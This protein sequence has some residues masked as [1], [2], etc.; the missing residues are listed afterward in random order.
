MLAFAFYLLKVIICSAV[1]FGYYWFFLRNKIFHSYNRFYLLAI[2]VLSLALPLMKISVWH[3][4]SESQPQVIRMLQVVNSSDEYLDEIVVYSHYNHISKEQ[5]FTGLY[6]AICTV[7]LFLLLQ[8][9]FRIWMLLKKNPATTIENIHFINT[10]AKG[11]PF[12]FLKF[13]FWNDAID[14]HTKTGRQVFKHEVAHVQEK[15]SYDKLFINIILILF[16]CNPFFWFIRKELNMIHEFIADK[17][18]VEDGDTADFAAMILQATYPQ[19]RFPI[20]NNFFYSPIKRR[21]IMLTKQNKTKV[22]YISRL[23]VLPL[24]IF[25]FAAFTIKAKTYA[26]GSNNRTITV[27]ID[28]GHG[29]TDAGATSPIDG[30]TYEKDLNLIIAQ[31]IRALNTNKDINILLTRESDIYQSPKEKAAYAEKMNADLF[32]SI[33]FSSGPKETW[34]KSTGMQVFVPKEANT[35]S[36]LLASSI[37]NS[38]QNNYGLTVMPN[39]VQP[40]TNIWVLSESKC[41]AI[42]I[43]AGY[44]SNEKDLA[45]LKSTS[46]VETFA[47]NVLDAIK[48]YALNNPSVTIK[49]KKELWLKEKA[50]KEDNLIIMSKGSMNFQDKNGDNSNELIILN[51]RKYLAS[52][53]NNKTVTFSKAS[54]YSKNNAEM[55]EKF[56]PPAANGVIIF[57]NGII[58]NTNSDKIEKEAVFTYSSNIIEKDVYIDAEQVAD[59]GNATLLSI[60]KID[61]DKTDAP[62]IVLNGMTS[63]AK[64]VKNIEWPNLGYIRIL[65]PETAMKTYGSIGR[66]GVILINTKQATYLPAATNH[67]RFE[68]I[69]DFTIGN[70]SSLSPDAEEFKKQQTILVTDGFKF[71][72]SNVYFSGTGFKDVQM[73]SLNS[74]RLQSY[75]SVFEKCVPGT[76]VTFDNVR[77]ESEKDGLLTIEGKSFRLTGKDQTGVVQDSSN[78]IFTKVEI[79]PDFPGGKTAWQEYLKKNLDAAMP[80]KEGWKPGTYRIV[81]QFIV[82]EKG[83]ISDVKTTDKPTSKTAKQCI[84]LIKNGPKW[85]PA[86][87]NGKIVKAYK[88]QPVTFVVSE[89]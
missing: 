64:E 40:K 28:A 53:L 71:K 72:S 13:I 89:Q 33:H 75:K 55:L 54:L 62:L 81:V 50:G 69:A 73:I 14:I 70:I 78:K 19:H 84:D 74:D 52:Q 80:I 4:A 86:R 29:G 79:E 82:D 37:I 34:N 45:Y 30:T 21:L 23:L 15:H 60:T 38:F 22:N 26:D 2:V 18:A 20:A 12:S 59:K 66:N 35:G 61:L 25:V 56:G 9:M 1:L 31:K 87:Q 42:L 83:N 5:L 49:P 46:A 63:T 88:K 10:N 57:E 41:P 16:W 76:I 68:S 27:V 47:I 36:N 48:K 24:A 77:L 65:T 8:V 7:F 43:E 85:L 6:F 3:K 39:P 17:K 11:T 58:E 32:I 44:L 51:N 67:P